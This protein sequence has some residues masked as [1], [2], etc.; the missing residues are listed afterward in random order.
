MTT[1]VA[2]YRVALVQMAMADDPAVNLRAATERLRAA[3]ATGAQVI[4]LPELFRTRYFCQREDP[5]AFDLAE[6]VPGPT[7]AA[8]APLAAEL[9]VVVVAPLFE[10]R[11]PG[12]YHNSLV[13]LDADGALLGCYRKLHIPDDP[14]FYEKYYFAPGDLGVR[15]FPT[16][17]G[18]IGTLICWDQWFPEAA[19]LTAMAGADVLLYPT[20]IGWHPRD[21]AA[22]QTQQLNAWRAV[23]RGHAVANGVY[24]AAANRTGFEPDPGGGDG[25]QFWGRSFADDPFGVPL[26]EADESETTLLFTVDPARIE[27]VRRGWPFWRDRRLDLADGLAR[28]WGDAE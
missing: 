19:R 8:L 23:Q 11:A 2:P 25:L 24:V 27:E 17:F 26:A 14:A 28:R 18:R 1:T 16:R 22:V 21:P 12:L 9:G 3:A 6:P 7:T 15:V 10:R 5:A 4:C 20:A 13:V